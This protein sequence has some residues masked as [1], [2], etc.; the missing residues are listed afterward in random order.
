MKA[1]NKPVKKK[2]PSKDEVEKELSIYLTDLYQSIE[3]A[4][5]DINDNESVATEL[6][7]S[8]REATV[9]T[10]ITD[11]TVSYLSK[12]SSQY[13]DMNCKS[14]INTT[15]FRI[16]DYNI[17]VKK[18]N[19]RNI[20]GYNHT[21]T[22]KKYCRQYELFNGEHELKTL[23]LGYKLNNFGTLEEVLLT[24]PVSE[25]RN[26]WAIQLSNSIL[27]KNNNSQSGFN[28]DAEDDNRLKQKTDDSESRNA[29]T[30]S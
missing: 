5:N 2:I 7:N 25:K 30:G 28:F 29:D 6:I 10:M 9:T 16:K 27:Y 4:V 23:H 12:V 19:D 8:L 17:K 26:K 20:A 24:C 14:K 13:P 18:L 11:R 1:V 15:I 3:N 21:S 22:S